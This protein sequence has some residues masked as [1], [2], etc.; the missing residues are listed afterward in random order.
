MC[1]R[2]KF[3]QNQPNSFGD[4]EIFRFL[5]WP[6][7]TILDFEKKLLFEHS[8]GRGPQCWIFKFFKF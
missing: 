5:R 6:P 7:S 2:T 3:Q 1:Y 8:L 4:I